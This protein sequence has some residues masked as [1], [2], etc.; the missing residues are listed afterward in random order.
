MSATPNLSCKIGNALGK[1]WRGWLRIQDN[2]CAWLARRGL[3]VSV[4]KFL[5]LLVNLAIIGFLLYLSVWLVLPI[6]F[7]LFLVLLA[8]SGLETDQ[9]DDDLFKS[10]WKYGHAGYGQYNQDNIRVDSHDL[11][12]EEC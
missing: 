2:V 6:I 8:G 11:D 5:A 9:N 12:D 1:A 10:E 7:V 4:A 3:P